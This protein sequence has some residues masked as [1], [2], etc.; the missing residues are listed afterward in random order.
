MRCGERRKFKVFPDGPVVVMVCALKPGHGKVHVSAPY[1]NRY[2][3]R[4][5]DGEK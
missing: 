3:A 1:G 4:W 5:R 2:T